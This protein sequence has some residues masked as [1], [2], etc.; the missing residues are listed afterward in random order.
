MILRSILSSQQVTL[1]YL[2]LKR[3]CLQSKK[4]TKINVLTTSNL[5]LANS[6]LNLVEDRV[7]KVQDQGPNKLLSSSPKSIN[8][9]LLKN[10]III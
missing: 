4:L 7:Y 10:I 8:R 6:N 3:K 2:M 1:M 5:N 9:K